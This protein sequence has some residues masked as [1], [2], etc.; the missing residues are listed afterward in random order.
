MSI[1]WHKQPIY[2]KENQITLKLRLE[3]NAQR[4]QMSYL[5]R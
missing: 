1:Q 2:K 4:I 3:S 5:N